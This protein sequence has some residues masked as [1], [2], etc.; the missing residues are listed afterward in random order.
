M[1]YQTVLEVLN[2]IRELQSSKMV[3]TYFLD[4]L[5]KIGRFFKRSLV[6]RVVIVIIIDNKPL[7]C[8]CHPGEK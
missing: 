7:F 8:N 4:Y 3:Y 1:L 2:F 5:T 6:T